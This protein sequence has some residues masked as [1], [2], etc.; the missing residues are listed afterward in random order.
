MDL[1]GKH[2]ILGI[3]GSIAAYKSAYL[4]SA[5]KKAK[6]DVT[7]IMTKNATE[8]IAPLTFETLTG[9]RCLVD[10][11]DRNFQY[12]VEHVEL[13]KKADIFMIAPASADVIAKAAHGIADDMLTT[14]LLAAACPKIFA[15]AMNT[16]MFQN[17]ITQDNLSLLKKYGMTVITPQTGYLA[18]GDVGIGKMPEPEALY[19]LIMY[20]LCQ[21]NLCGVKVLVSAGP[22]REAIDPVRFVSNHS[23]GKM[24]FAIARAAARR[25]AD[26]TLVT[27]Q[28]NLATPLGVMRVDVT[29]AAEMQGAINAQAKNSDVIVMAAAIADYRPKHVADQKIKKSGDNLILEMM[30]TADILADLGA[31]KKPGQFLCGF[32]MESENMEKNAKE[33]LAKKNLDMIVANNIRTEGAGFAVDTNIVTLIDSE[34]ETQL[35]ILS[36]DEVAERI[37]DEIK[38]KKFG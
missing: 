3:T 12:E 35:P 36:K 17:P 10:T 37:L 8:F 16:R 32:A 14:T 6:A 26:V 19:E 15:P 31:N 22:T 2:I 33:K 38:R 1:S 28:V 7:V 24:G 18:C 20:T 27:G 13:A 5:L 4:A 21:K 11:F 29:S 34:G 30:R 9:N 23:S 25:G